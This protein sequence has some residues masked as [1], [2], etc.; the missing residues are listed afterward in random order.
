ML[1]IEGGGEL[2]RTPRLRL[3]VLDGRRLA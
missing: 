2:R 3:A 1:G